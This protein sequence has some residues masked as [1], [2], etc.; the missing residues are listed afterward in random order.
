MEVISVLQQGQTT[1]DAGSSAWGCVARAFSN[2]FSASF[3]D[4]SIHVAMQVSQ[5]QCPSYDKQFV[6]RDDKVGR[7]AS[8]KPKGIFF[9]ANG[10]VGEVV[11]PDERGENDVFN[12]TSA[13]KLHMGQLMVFRERVGGLYGARKFTSPCFMDY[14]VTQD[15]MPVLYSKIDNSVWV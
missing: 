11:L 13:E 1:S 3:T 14:L 8:S 5:K 10:A 15:A 2:A 7:T 6:H 9:L 12:T 4:C